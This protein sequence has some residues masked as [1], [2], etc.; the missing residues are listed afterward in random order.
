[1]IKL[2]NV[3]KTFFP[4]TSNEVLAL[5]NI[6]LHLKEGD[7]VTIIGS[8]GAGKSTFLKAVAGIE[9]IDTGRIELAGRDVTGLPEYKRAKDIGRIDQDPLASTVAEMTIEENMAMAYKRGQTRGLLRAI[10]PS[11]ETIFR[12]ALTAIGMGL[13]NRLRVPVRTLSGGQRQALS[14][15]MATIAQPKL[16]LLDEHTA[17]LDPKT[18]KQ[19]MDITSQVVA[20]RRLTTLMITHNMDQAIKFGNRLIMMHRGQIILDI[21]EAEKS[22]LTVAHL[23]D[24]F[25][26]AS[27]AVFDDDR[28]LLAN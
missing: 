10:T 15:V 2:T 9:M 27:G 18:A 16:L 6:N 4:G 5:N 19:I 23:I 17:A 11:R 25:T 7:F 13:E 22:K 1:M 8:N 3:Y 24:Q 28:V 21:D 12:E 20:A 14:L 26:A